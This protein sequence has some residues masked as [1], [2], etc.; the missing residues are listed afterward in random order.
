MGPATHPLHDGYQ[1][2]DRVNHL[3]HQPGALF[4]YLGARPRAPQ[5]VGQ[6]LPRIVR[7]GAPLSE[8][9]LNALPTDRG[10][11]Q[12]GGQLISLRR[13]RPV[14]RPLIAFAV[15]VVGMTPPHGEFVLVEAIFWADDA[16][17]S[18]PRFEQFRLV[19][20]PADEVDLQPVAPQFYR[21]VCTPLPSVLR[22]P[23]RLRNRV[24]VLPCEGVCVDEPERSRL[25][26]SQ[27]FADGFSRSNQQCLDF[28]LG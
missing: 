2:A 13:L 14:P 11:G 21:D 18:E 22:F 3:R 10:K 9:G 7:L 6:L 26:L 28:K 15:V 1:L 12:P 23:V 5:V 4:D 20:C 8:E 17:R 24:G 25:I 19:D 27:P 16:A